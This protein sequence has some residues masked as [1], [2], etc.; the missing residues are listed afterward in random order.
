MSPGRAFVGTPEQVI[1]QMQP[2][3]DLGVNYFMLSSV[4]FPDLT[5]LE[6]L[7]HEVMPALNQ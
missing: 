7:I 1:E 2:F 3:L 4:G 6:T 5:T